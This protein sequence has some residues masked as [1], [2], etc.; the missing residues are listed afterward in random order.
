MLVLTDDVALD[1]GALRFRTQGSAGGHNGLKSM[2]S[3]LQTNTY[4]RLRIGI[5]S[6][7]DDLVGHV[8]GEFTRSERKL[9]DIVVSDAAWAVEQ[10]IEEDDLDLVK[11]N[12]NGRKY[13]N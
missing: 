2:Q 9:V 1:F 8:L 12:I 10:W 4:N 13:N 3:Y 5:G 7:K 6:P 11:A